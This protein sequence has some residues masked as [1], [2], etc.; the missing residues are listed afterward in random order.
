VILFIIRSNSRFLLLTMQ[1]KLIVRVY[2]IST[3]PIHS[4][5]TPLVVHPTYVGNTSIF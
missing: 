2:Y 5:E 1:V 3:V 4:Y